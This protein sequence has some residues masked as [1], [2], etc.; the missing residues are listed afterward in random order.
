LTTPASEAIA[1]ARLK[2]RPARV[3]LYRDRIGPCR[4]LEIQPFLHFSGSL[5][6]LGR[7]P[8]GPS[9][10]NRNSQ[11]L[12]MPS[13]PISRPFGDSKAV[14]LVSLRYPVPFTRYSLIGFPD[15]KTHVCLSRQVVLVAESKHSAHAAHRTLYSVSR[16]CLRSL[17][18]FPYSVFTFLRRCRFQ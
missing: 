10:K 5:R 12:P 3:I 1:S 17:T 14:S 7:P 16:K 18:P 15:A 2:F 13:D 8:P 11:T 9:Q 6:R 4:R